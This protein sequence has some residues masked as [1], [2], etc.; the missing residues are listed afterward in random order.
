MT[1]VDNYR[2]KLGGAELVPIVVGGMGV[3]ISTAELALEACRLGGVGHISDAMLPHVCDRVFGTSYVKQKA[4]KNQDATVGQGHS[5]ARFDLAQLR[6]IETRYVRDVMSR[7]RGAGMIFVNV[8][9]KL[10][11]GDPI[12]TLEAR[13]LGALDGGVDGITLAAGLHTHS[14]RLMSSHPRFRE[15][16][17]GIIVSSARALKLFLRSAGRSERWPD[18]VIVEGPLAGGH[19]G[20][21]LDWREF[22]LRTITQ[23]VIEFIKGEGLDIPV[24]AAGGIFTGS[25]AAE[26]LAL[27]AK[28]VQVATRFSIS[29]EAG[30]PYQAKQAYFK[31]HEADVVVNCVSPTGYLMR[32]LTYSPC[33][34][35]NVAP[36]CLANGYVLG[37]EGACQYIAA[38]E[39][40]GLDTQGARLPVKDKICLCYHFGRYGCFT[41]GHYVYRLK[42]TTNLLPDGSYQVPT[43]EW[44]FKDYQFST[45][46]KIA[47]PPLATGKV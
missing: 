6:E 38:Y 37:R 11:M 27:G 34:S 26:Y 41:C 3:N 43:A 30:L 24:I 23:E 22:T 2:W 13:L 45:D 31:S 40:T 7:K 20:F 28:A 42:E 14:F 36:N 15:A 46:Q 19:L 35:S 18:Y 33:L 4:Q 29:Q 1:K 9:E 25:D 12:G 39:N 17:L 21:G 5:T 47:L 16:K 32:M 10:T 8:M 44:I